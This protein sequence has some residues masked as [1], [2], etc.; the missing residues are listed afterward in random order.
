MWAARRAGVCLCLLGQPLPF[1]VPAARGPLCHQLSARTPAPSPEAPLCAC[2]VSLGSVTKE[3]R[4]AP[5]GCSPARLTVLPPPWNMYRPAGDLNPA[6]RGLC[7]RASP[8]QALARL[9]C[10]CSRTGMQ[11]GLPGRTRPL[12]PPGPFCTGC[13][14]YGGAHQGF[15]RTGKQL[16]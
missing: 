7:G 16:S 4:C 5:A 11:R 12:R 6:L 8:P 9:G 10:E 2:P 1:S 15:Q 14:A 13:L 3:R